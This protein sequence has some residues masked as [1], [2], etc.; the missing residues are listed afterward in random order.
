[1]VTRSWTEVIDT[2]HDG[3]AILD[4]ERRFT[5]VSDQFVE[6]VGLAAP[7]LMGIALLDA[8]PGLGTTEDLA[9]LESDT[10]IRLEYR[11]E[12]PGGT[13][14]WVWLTIVDAGLDEG[15]VVVLSQNA[16]A[17][18]TAL[19]SRR[20]AQ[21]R[22]TDVADLESARICDGLHDGP[23]QLLAALT[24]RLDAAG[25]ATDG[26][27]AAEL[28]A[29][30][31][32]IV[33]ELRSIL[34]DLGRVDDGQ[35]IALLEQWLAPFTDAPSMTVTLTDRT[36][37]PPNRAAVELL[38]LFAYEVLRAV[39]SRTDPRTV[40][41]VFLEEGGGY[42]M[43]VTISLGPDGPLLSGPVMTQIRSVESYVHG[44]GGEFRV[45][46]DAQFRSAR[47]WIPADA[48]A[49]RGAESADVDTGPTESVD[50]DIAGPAP[51]AAAVDGTVPELLDDAGW[52]A[53]GRASH[54][55]LMEIDADLRITY[56]NEAYT[57]AM[58]VDPD[59][60]RGR[61]LESLFSA[62]DYQRLLPRVDQVRAGRAIRFDW[63]RLN[64]L[65]ETRWVQV[66]ASPRLTTAGEFDGALLVTRDTTDLHNLEGL[67]DAALADLEHARAEAADRLVERVRE[68]LEALRQLDARLPALA[69]A[70]LSEGTLE[71]IRAGLRESLQRLAASLDMFAPSHL[72][73]HGFEEALRA[74]LSPFVEGRPVTVDVVD[75]TA[76]AMSHTQAE[77]VFRI[78]REAC[79]NAIVHGQAHRI[80]VRLTERMA[81]F[82]LEIADDGLGIDLRAIETSS[83]HRGV[84]SMLARA[85]Q[86]GGRCHIGLGSNGGTV[87]SAWV[88][89]GP[90]PTGAG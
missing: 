88:P 5:F 68:P 79:V 2:L 80:D 16:S 85:H 51:S 28:R 22:L 87:V 56:V 15:S 29:D 52:E 36:V 75:D 46:D 89:L 70:G 82:G 11:S 48:H 23:I 55:G 47:F 37:T 58:G 4:A 18:Q 1:M 44:L 64:A 59:A 81:G 90:D 3:L 69:G 20:A 32:A 53:I 26:G 43:E 9:A 62:R 83:G 74:A 50:R 10:S 66:A 19:A 25:Q 49:D 7:S 61:P 45:R 40:E 27:A 14:R 76:N 60:L 6:S 39:R 73:G 78:A 35:G 67:Y 34:A 12:G 65:G 31:D 57:Q 21:L 24:L 42:A 13:R 86:L 77:A 54:E 72:G 8:L 33:G 17:T 38:F 84:R 41:I 63:Q 71:R 30:I